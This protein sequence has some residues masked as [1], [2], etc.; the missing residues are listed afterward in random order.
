[1]KLGTTMPRGDRHHKS[2]TLAYRLDSAVDLHKGPTPSDE[3][4]GLSQMMRV[5]SWRLAA[6]EPPNNSIEP[7]DLVP[8][9]M[10]HPRNAPAWL[11][12]NNQVLRFYGF[13]Q[14]HVSERSEENCRYRQVAILYHMEDGTIRITEPK[15]ENSGI[16]QGAFLKRHRVPRD[17]GQ[18]YLGPDDFRIG[19][20]LAIYGRT[21][22]ITGC[23]RFTRWFY[24]ENGIDVGEDEPPVED[25]WTKNTKFQNLAQKGLLPT[26]KCCFE[27]KTLIKYQVGQP[28]AN[29]KEQQFLLNDR[30][31]LR[32][33]AYWDDPTPYGSRMY[34]VLHYY[35]ADNTVEV[36]EAHTRNSGR[37]GFPVFLRRTKLYKNHNPAGIPGLLQPEPTEYVPEDFRV[38]DCVYV[39]RRK[40]VLYHCDDA[41]RRFYKEY[42]GIDQHDNIID[43]SDP[44]K[45]R[46]KLHPPPHN[47]LG[48]DEDSLQ[49]CYLLQPKPFKQDLVRLMTLSGEVLRFEARM[50]N[51]EPEDESRRFVIA[52]YPADDHVAVFEVQQRNSGH[53]AGKFA[54]KKRM[55][56]PE[57]GKSFVPQDFF[58]GQTVEIASQPFQIVRADEHCLQFME[59]K[60]DVFPYADPVACAKKLKP[61]LDE[62]AMQGPLDPDQLKELAAN[63]GIFFVDHEIITLLRRFTVDSGPDGVPLMDGSVVLE[64]AQMA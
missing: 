11:K 59:G 13:F 3:A 48:S 15:V 12:H 28:P 23:D 36:N 61:L 1:M 64:V 30:K 21:Y 10:V 29:M 27:A 49:S 17:D 32:F 35:L 56:N 55:K 8:K 63:A 22:H 62:P 34:F 5:P 16:P 25:L 20:E 51:G 4:K 42:L 47:G 37:D 41:T 24:E 38:G 33:K 46:N 39:F 2:I 57:T 53:M 18:A 40:I 60:P 7:E 58:I 43:V 52:T 19:T 26:S 44:P 54:E 45:R 50:V 6:T 31:V 14:E 9:N